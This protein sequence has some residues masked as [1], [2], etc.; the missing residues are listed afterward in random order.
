MKEQL[1]PERMSRRSPRFLHVKNPE[2]DR[3]WIERHKARCQISESGCWLWTAGKTATGYG[4]TSYRNK[5]STVHRAMYQAHHGVKLTTKQ[6]VC[7]HCDT[8]HCC[9]PDHL[10]LG[11]QFANMHDSVLKGR[12]AEQ[13][14]THC[15]RGHAYDA[16]NTYVTSAGSRH[17]KTC[18]R[19][20][21]RI[22]AGWP[23]HLAYSL[24]QVPHGYTMEHVC[25]K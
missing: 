2:Y 21:G 20:R 9:N 22:A 23:E 18:S 17:C 11:D 13:L 16:T 6:Y 24:P 12:H 5:P 1:S 15:P 4:C 19:A 7:H 25:Q 8:R 3:N 10:F 14:V